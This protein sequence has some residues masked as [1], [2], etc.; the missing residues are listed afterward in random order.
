MPMATILPTDKVRIEL[1]GSFQ[2]FRPGEDRPCV[3]S[4][5]LC[6]A[7]LVFLCVHSGQEVAR[8]RL[9][10]L[11]WD[12]RTEA[13]GRQYLR[14]LLSEL[15]D[16]VGDALETI[17]KDSV[18][19]RAESV[20]ID[21]VRFLRLCRSREL[22]D[23][24]EAVSLYR[25][26]LT[27]NVQI[28]ANTFEE[29]LASERRRLQA[30]AIDVFDTCARAVA[31]DNRPSQ[32]LVLAE[33]LLEM[34][35]LREPTHRLIISLEA[36]VNGR[37]SALSRA[38]ELAAILKAQVGVAPEQ[39]TQELVA[40]ISAGSVVAA[41]SGPQNFENGYSAETS[42]PPVTTA[43]R[44]PWLPF[45]AAAAIL[46]AIPAA[47]IAFI[48]GGL[49][50]NRAPI[51]NTP[52]ERSSETQAVYSIAVLPFTPRRDDSALLRFL[53]T[54]EQDLIE[55]FS[56]VTRFEVTSYLTSRTYRAMQQDAREIGKDLGVSFLLAGNADVEADKFV[57]RAQLIDTQSGKLAWSGRF[58]YDPG[59]SE[60]VF[61]DIV[62]GI[63]RE[64]QIEVLIF[65]G[66]RRERLERQN[67]TY[68]DLLQR[69]VAESLRAFDN[70]DHANTALELFEKA[71]AINPDSVSAKVGIAR[72]LTRRIAEL[73]STS[74]EQDMERLEK[75][76]TEA[77]RASPDSSSGRY[78]LG[79][80]RKL[81]GRIEDSIAEFEETLRLN[82][83]HANAHAQIGHSLIFLGRAQETERHIQ[84]AIRLSPRD[85]T[86][87]FWF[88]AAGQAAIYLG[89]YGNA[90]QWF[91]KSV[92]SSPKSVR[93]YVY[94]AI[95]HLLDGNKEKAAQSATIAKRLAPKLSAKWL[96]SR[97]S[98]AGHPDYV[99]QHEKVVEAFRA[100]LALVPSNQQ[101][102]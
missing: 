33:R 2:V 24:E 55:S 79:I 35:A 91:E 102:N 46:V 29:W 1:L 99:R 5:K 34:D 27:S 76:L 32:A 72:V 12:S 81:Q 61:E 86:I 37:S 95:A 51:A 74:R 62:L 49:V 13:S 92:A 21:L 16:A 39:T 57:V 68:G 3:L 20:E 78:F 65:E 58:E 52:A 28:E 42:V 71:L 70:P 88:L 38:A 7:L 64:L 54:L 14:Q 67:P 75:L 44:R 9:I 66:L 31:S 59:G 43:A 94:L 82:P 97:A 36:T 96:Q 87:S 101:A 6:R 60:G 93:A 98:R 48:N 50:P 25:G 53:E 63:A 45:L 56:R 23:L 17:G 40:S 8:A 77:V 4:S 19:L 30:I 84:K 41:S 11:L 10:D 15:R 83:S 80:L 26:E 18:R 100:A 89:K 90:I 22:A 69:G 73:R 85:P 47:W